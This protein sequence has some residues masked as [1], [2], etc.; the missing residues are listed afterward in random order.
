[1]SDRVVVTLNDFDEERRSILH[2]FREQ[3]EQIAFV[4]KIHQ[5]PELLQ[6][7]TRP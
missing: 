7:K 2:E 4:V 6:L 5:N 3:L 1:M